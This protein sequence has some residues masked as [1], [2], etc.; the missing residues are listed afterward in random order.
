MRFFL[1]TEFTHLVDPQLIS[2]GI[3]SENGREYYREL[4]DTW[5][6][7]QCSLFV[8]G[9]VLPLLS[10]G[11]TGD[12]LNSRL[13]STLDL[14]QF[15]TDTD[16]QF[17]KQRE[18]LLNQHLESDPALMDHLRFLS[19]KDTSDL[20]VRNNH[21][22]ADR[23]RGLSPESLL[24]G[25]QVMTGTQVSQDLPAWLDNFDGEPTVCIDSQYDKDLLQTLINQTL[26]FELIPNLA[27]HG[28]GLQ[29]HHALADARELRIGFLAEYG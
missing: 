21:F 5:T 9:W 25:E 20:Y 11:K 22:L 26:K 19:G 13:Q 1:D 27:D 4:K 3:V 10:N 16:C 12:R 23:L 14:I 7:S 24:L 15:A 28:S 17:S 29:R 18:K 8:L 2:F 6:L